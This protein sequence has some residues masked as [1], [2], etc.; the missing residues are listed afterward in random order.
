MTMTGVMSSRRAATPV[1]G[2]PSPGLG[3]I[4]ISLRQGQGWLGTGLTGQPSLG[5]KCGEGSKL[6]PALAQALETLPSLVLPEDNQGC[7]R[8]SPTSAPVS[9][10]C[11]GC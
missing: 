5:S 4:P 6:G 11:V 8:G 9:S 7:A 1:P 3:L 10:G 2:N